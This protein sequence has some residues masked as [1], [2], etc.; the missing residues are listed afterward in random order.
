M[1]SSVS[2]IVD[3]LA[4]GIHKIKYKDNKIYTKY[5]CLIKYKWY[6]V[7]KIIQ[8]RL[9]KNEKSDPGMH[10]SFLIVVEYMDKWEKFNETSLPEKDAESYY[11]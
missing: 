5:N 1:A 3:N 2:S 4:E 7:T 8:R 9:M 10:S 6:L 11:M